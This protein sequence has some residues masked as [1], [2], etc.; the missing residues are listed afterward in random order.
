MKVSM[1][2][3]CAP[4]DFYKLEKVLNFTA[5]CSKKPDEVILGISQIYM[6]QEAE[7]EKVRKLGPQLFNEFKITGTN[8]RCW[9]GPNRQRASELATGDIIIYQDADDLPQHQRVELI[10]RFFEEKD[11]LHLNHAYFH[12]AFTYEY[13][14][15]YENIKFVE[16]DVIYK[17][18]FPTGDLRE[19]TKVTMSYGYDLGFNFPLIHVGATSIRRSVLEKIQWK[20][21]K[22]LTLCTDPGTVP[23]TED[24]EFSMSILHTFNKSLLIDAPLYYYYT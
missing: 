15:S 23:R 7:L 6:F 16:S 4:K 8:D 2:I 20:D 18:Y 17:R 12:S 1:V 9:P 3:P 14:T 5:S 21:V 11:I 19:C 13:R 22:D 24:Y 10:S